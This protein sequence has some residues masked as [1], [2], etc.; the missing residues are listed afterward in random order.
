[1]PTMREVAAAA[2]VSTATVSRVANGLPGV[3]SALK[4]RVQ[5]VIDEM[6]YRPNLV[7][8]GLRMQTTPLVALVIP[9]IENAFFTSICRGVEDVARRQK[10]S[11][12]LCNT[13]EDPAKESSYLDILAAHAV[14]G[15]IISAASVNSDVSPL[16]DLGIAV[17]A[18][19]RRI[20][21]ELDCVRSDSEGGARQATRH[22]ISFGAQRVAC[23]TGPQDVVTAEQRLD[24]Y[25]QALEGFSKE[26]DES[27][28]VHTNFKEDGAYRAMN[29]LL[30]LDSPPDA[31][32]VANNRMV[33]GAMRACRERG[34][35]VPDQVSLVGFDDLPWADL[36][37]P[38]IT[39][40]R[41]PTYEIGAAAA[42]LLLE[43]I[44]G[45]DGPGRE[46]VFQPELAVRQ[47]SIKRGAKA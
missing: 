9:D 24:G 31:V 16:T 15:V 25:R 38:S 34:V 45:E 42:R 3:D 22:L 44:N 26:I 10:Y 13:D 18:V 17:V 6:G 30:D 33:I 1:M 46:I 4:K 7:A 19:G 11:V 32:F 43:R 35:A 40:M 2:G 39:T 23:I 28:I 14:S 36:T 47:S 12:M 20:G 37:T 29:Q 41:Q 27:L 21:P 5:S 8:R